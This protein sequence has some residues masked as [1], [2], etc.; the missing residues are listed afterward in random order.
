MFSYIFLFLSS[1]PFLSSDNNLKL[2]N[3]YNVIFTAGLFSY[4]IL[5]LIS[6]VL[7]NLDISKFPNLNLINLKGNKIAKNKITW[8]SPKTIIGAHYQTLSY[9]PKVLNSWR[10]SQNQ[11]TIKRMIYTEVGDFFTLPSGA[12][13]EVPAECF[14]GTG[15]VTILGDVKIEIKEFTTP[16][17]YALT[18]YPTYL[19][20]GEISDT[21]YAI[22]IRAFH[23]N[24][25]VY[26]KSEKPILIYPSFKKQFSLDKYFYLNYKSEWQ[27][28]NQ[29]SNIC[30]SESDSKITPNSPLGA[31]TQVYVLPFGALNPSVYSLK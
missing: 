20:N 6:L 4:S 21:K 31:S 2:E 7:I 27:R 11:T 16:A 22:E 15:N 14:I 19:P 30:R 28:L 9:E 24:K 10:Y 26:V 18:K 3:I 23:K 8:K 5:G 1:I 17:D 13:V 25:E 12:K 29:A